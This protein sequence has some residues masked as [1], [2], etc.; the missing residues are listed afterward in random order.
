VAESEGRETPSEQLAAI[1]AE[2]LR[3]AGLIREDRVAGVRVQLAAGTLKEA[4][5]RL[6]IENGLPRAGAED[7][8]VPGH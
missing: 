3:A 4:E 6:L 8:N 2:A 7:K 1:I 5:W